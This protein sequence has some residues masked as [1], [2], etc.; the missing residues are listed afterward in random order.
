[1][2]KHLCLALWLT[3]CG[4]DP[5]G[6]SGVLGGLPPATI[7]TSADMKVW[8]GASAA[9]SYASGLEPLFLA[10]FTTGNTPRTCPAATTSGTRTTYTGGCT[11][12]Q[13]DTWFGTATEDGDMTAG[14]TITYSGFGYDGMTTC[15]NAMYP[16]RV[17][18]NGTVHQTVSDTTNDFSVD[19][20]TNATGVNTMTCVTA[21]GTSAISYS[22]TF[23]PTGADT[24][25]DGKPDGKLWEGSGELGNSLYGKVSATTV[26]EL[27][28]NS[29]CS[30]EPASGTTTVTTRGHVAVITYDGATSCDQMA[31]V[32][33]TL[34]GVDQGTITGV[35]CNAGGRGSWP[36]AVALALVLRSRRWRT[37]AAKRSTSARNRSSPEA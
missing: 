33:W 6:S 19:I 25:G 18:Y 12:D 9:A 26:D 11:D 35:S 13:G 21:S 17:T 20:T 32:S 29:V 15:M 10:T 37:H 23:T 14:G 3:A 7:A 5:S 16:S 24:N 36:L 4:T 27:I 31:T 1:M 34:D 2:G 22:G 8:S 28:D 30:H